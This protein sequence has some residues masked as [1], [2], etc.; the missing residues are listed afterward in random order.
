MPWFII[1]KEKKVI[2]TSFVKAK[3]E[4]QDKIY[5]RTKDN[6]YILGKIG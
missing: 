5:L 6:M 1:A 4:T 2:V 3:Q